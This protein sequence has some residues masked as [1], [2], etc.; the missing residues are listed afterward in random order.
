[1]SQKQI[2]A[3]PVDQLFEVWTRLSEQERLAFGRRVE[4]EQDRVCPPATLLVERDALFLQNARPA[5]LYP[6]FPRARGL[7]CPMVA[8]E[9]LFA[10]CFAQ[11]WEQIP[12]EDRQCLLGYWR[13]SADRSPQLH[14]RITLVDARRNHHRLGT[15]RDDGHTLEFN[16]SLTAFFR[17]R[18]EHT[19]AHELAHAH[20]YATGEAPAS[21]DREVFDRID[22]WWARNPDANEKR[23]RAMLDSL[24]RKWRRLEEMEA[25]RLV[26][27][28]GVPEASASRSGL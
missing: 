10:R 17:D 22:A 8:D 19:I 5:R 2:A 12:N 21:R 27:Q 24:D 11:V 14:P 16:A 18:L 13:P 4:A 7:R 1:M 15:C 25:E 23:R 3:T 20:R 6:G 26:R 28:W 9:L